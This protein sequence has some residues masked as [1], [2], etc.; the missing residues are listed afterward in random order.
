MTI[1]LAGPRRRRGLHHDVVDDLG[2]AL[3]RG[4]WRAGEALP[5]E[6][7]LALQLEVS[8][9]VVREAIKVLA[10]KGLVES[11]P[12]TGTR[13][14]ERN[15]WNLTDP[16]VLRWQLSGGVDVALCR[17][18]LE[19]RGILEPRAAALAA[20]R[21]TDAE[22]D[23]LRALLDE[24]ETL[25]HDPPGYIVSDLRFHSTILEIS[26]NV[27]LSQLAATIRAAL[28]AVRDVTVRVPGGPA[29]AMAAHRRVADAVARGDGVTAAEAMAA[30]IEET[31]RDFET[32]LAQD[33][34]GA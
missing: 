5:P 14:L 29:R 1:Q 8:R 31:T 13:A 9:T 15:H 17:E 24:M 20:T 2:Q 28:V 32:V 4:R 26:Q 23:R 30:L 7:E 25:V 22:A 11:R 33:M 10:S 27:L 21:R 12:K 16:D 19:V 3:V 34:G 18:L 6:T